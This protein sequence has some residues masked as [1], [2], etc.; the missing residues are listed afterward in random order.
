MVKFSWN[1]KIKKWICDEDKNLKISRQT[2]DRLK[3]NE[4]K[5]KN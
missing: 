3:R 1:S 2:A 4:M 5:S